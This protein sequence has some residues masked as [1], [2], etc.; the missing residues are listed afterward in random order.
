VCRRLPGCHCPPLPPP[1]ARGV[2]ERELGSRLRG[3][4][5][6]AQ[7]QESSASTAL[8]VLGWHGGCRDG[9]DRFSYLGH[10]P[11]TIPTPERP[12][13]APTPEESKEATHQR[14]YTVF[15]DW[16][17]R[18]GCDFWSECDAPEELA[19]LAVELNDAF[20]KAA[21]E[22]ERERCAEIVRLCVDTTT[23]IRD[24]KHPRKP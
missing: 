21:V 7:T 1:A 16:F 13:D 23:A 15:Y 9:R 8:V 5:S 11:M 22:K 18:S 10:K 2:R 24:I 19:T 14:F 17:M 4:G 20:A 3:L 6:D 12:T